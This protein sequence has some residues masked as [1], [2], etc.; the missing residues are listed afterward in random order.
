MGLQRKKP[1]AR[2]FDHLISVGFSVEELAPL[3]A[4]QYKK[5]QNAGKIKVE[6]DFGEGLNEFIKE[7]KKFQELKDTRKKNG[8]PD[9]WG[10]NDILPRMQEVA[11]DLNKLWSEE[12]TIDPK[13]DKT[14]YEAAVKDLDDRIEATSNKFIKLYQ[15]LKGTGGSVPNTKNFNVV[16]DAIEDLQYQID[17]FE[18]GEIKFDFEFSD[19]SINAQKDRVKKAFNDLMSNL[20]LDFGQLITDED[21]KSM[22]NQGQQLEDIKKKS[23]ELD[24]VIKNLEKEYT[25]LS[26]SVKQT[27][28]PDVIRESVKSEIDSAKEQLDNAKELQEKLKLSSK[29]VFE[30]P[31]DIKIGDFAKQQSEL[32]QKIKAVTNQFSSERDILN[33]IKSDM[34]DISPDSELG[35]A[36]QKS[37][38]LKKEIDSLEKRYQKLN[39]KLVEHKKILEGIKDINNVNTVTVKQDI[40]GMLKKYDQDQQPYHFDKAA[41]FYGISGSS[42]TITHNGEDITQKLVERYKQLVAIMSDAKK[43]QKEILSIHESIEQK[44]T[45]LINADADIL[46]L[47]DQIVAQKKKKEATE[48]STDATEKQAKADEKAAE[49]SEKKAEADEE[50]AKAAEKRSEAQ[51]K[52]AEQSSDNSNNN[53]A[54]TPVK[55]KF[56]SK[57]FVKEITDKLSADGAYVDVKVKS[58]PIDNEFINDVQ[59]QIDTLED[60]SKV[61]LKADIYIDKPDDQVKNIESSFVDKQVPIDGKIVINNIDQ[62]VSDIESQLTGK[63]VNIDVKPSETSINNFIDSVQ[64]GL[65]NTVNASDINQVVVDQDKLQEELK[66]SE[67]TFK[68]LKSAII[69]Y[70]NALDNINTVSKNGAIPNLNQRRVL[71]SDAESAASIYKESGFTD[72]NAENILV[73]YISRLKDAE[74]ALQSFGIENNE[75]IDK[76]KNKLQTAIDVQGEYSIASQNMVNAQ[77][78]LSG[79]LKESYLSDTNKNEI[80]DFLKSINSDVSIKKFADKVKELFGI[81]IPTSVKQAKQAVQDLNV[82]VEKNDSDNFVNIPVKPTVNA[83]EFISGADGVNAQVKTAIGNGETID[84]VPVGIKIKEIDVGQLITDINTKVSAFISANA[85]D[86]EKIPLTTIIDG[87]MDEGVNT[88]IKSLQKLVDFIHNDVIGSIKHKTDQF[89]LESQSVSSAVGLEIKELAKLADFINNTVVKAIKNKANAFDNEATTV[90][91]SVTREKGELSKLIRSLKDVESTIKGISQLANK[92]HIN[93]E[94]KSIRDLNDALDKLK[95]KSIPDFSNLNALNDAIKLTKGRSESFDNYASDIASGLEKLQQAFDKGNYSQQINNFLQQIQQLVNASSQFKEIVN[96]LNNLDKIGKSTTNDAIKNFNKATSDYISAY[97][98]NSKNGTA[99]SASKLAIANQTLEETYK[100]LNK[101]VNQGLMTSEE[102]NRMY[103]DRMKLISSSTIAINK[104]K[105]NNENATIAIKEYLSASKELYKTKSRMLEGQSGSVIDIDKLEQDVSAAKNLL[106]DLYDSGKVAEKDYENAISKSSEFESSYLD[107]ASKITSKRL[108]KIS[109]SLKSGNFIK[110]IEQFENG[111]RSFDGLSGDVIGKI[112]QL[113]DAYSI[114]A[115]DSSTAN[116]KIQASF[117]FSNV[118]K[119]LSLLLSDLKSQNPFKELSPKNTGYNFNEYVNL[120][121]LLKSK[122]DELQT[123]INTKKPK[124]EINSLRENVEQLRQALSDI[125]KQDTSKNYLK[126]IESYSKAVDSF[127]SKNLDSVYSSVFDQTNNRFKELNESL[128]SGKIELQDYINEVNKLAN[129]LNRTAQYMGGNK[130]FDGS[131]SSDTAALEAFKQ[132]VSGLGTIVKDVTGDTSDNTKEVSKWSAVYKEAD[133]TVKKITATFDKTTGLMS[134]NTKTIDKELTGVAGAIDLLKKKYKELMVYWTSMALT[135]MSLIRYVKEA[136]NIVQQYDDALTEMRKVTDTSVDTLKEFQK[137]SFNLANAVGTTGL[138]IQKSTADWLRLGKGFEEAKRAASETN[139]LMNVSE[140]QSID[141]AT[142]SMIAMK[143]AY[144]ELDYRQIIDELNIVGNSFSISTSDLAQGLQNA[145]AAL[146]TQG[147]SIEESIA[148]I[149]AGNSIIQDVQKVAAG[150]RTISLR[151]ASS[152]ISKKQLE[153]LGE[154]VQDYIVQTRAKL[155]E[156]IKSLTKTESNKEGVNIIDPNGSLKSTYQILKEIS[157][158]Y[159]EIQKEDKQ[160]GTNRA[161]A[162]VEYLAKVCKC[163]QK[164]VLITHLKP[165][166]PKALLPQCG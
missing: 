139:V 41:M 42:E 50:A 126:S 64:Q 166:K 4:D 150:V 58:K 104:E 52:D 10:I 21:I 85:N 133:G 107:K 96:A 157:G 88:E 35:K 46:D 1:M 16:N 123:A 24:G 13:I 161:S 89:T 48:E 30:N 142:K 31:D 81:E 151:I 6:Y 12:I 91:K 148:L 156:T 65:A 78:K 137:E 43:K 155:Q 158:V 93:I 3:L 33:R 28:M 18:K 34:S 144:D 9:Q 116:E 36:I 100:A 135:P 124:E 159:Q 22:E 71:K 15:L 83:T 72:T 86:F 25:S 14:G 82:T 20:G 54:E 79:V 121:D 165:V 152:E 38:S 140:F 113:R 7:A 84:P 129:D 143:Q 69:D 47:Y 76:I 125:G 61:K 102:V 67:L 163:T 57:E 68:N 49:A 73:R 66:E 119:E 94:S 131:F 132:T 146:K 44:S 105:Q 27:N 97:N 106:D 56:D 77:M 23:K 51:E 90:G 130:L 2:D 147:N 141:E 39:A 70:N 154:D 112:E 115:N 59:T 160:F 62:K 145:A 134:T 26:R 55:P 74:K 19:N 164:Y 45:Q 53:P 5:A 17:K 103:V 40:E 120:F 60:A 122:F 98:T 80:N 138:Q 111:F 128:K 37:E 136:V 101:T 162:L 8:N 63:S 114:M 95:L 99:E 92:I 11:K 87:S 110:V 108:D 118:R 75:V 153:E 29:D 117:D 32:E 149:T 109:E 127:K